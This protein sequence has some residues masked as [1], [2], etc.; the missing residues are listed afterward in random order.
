M[1]ELVV[2]LGD[3]VLEEPY[4][5]IAGQTYT[6]ELTGRGTTVTGHNEQTPRP[7]PPEAG[8]VMRASTDLTLR[9]NG[10]A[11]EP[12]EERELTPYVNEQVGEWV[13][14]NEVPVA[15]RLPI[16]NGEPRPGLAQ[17][18]HDII[19]SVRRTT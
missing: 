14:R 19:V 11:W 3:T 10:S 15:W 17:V 6:M 8:T 5:L 2:M 4:T 9:W 1:S 7:H 12:Y 16:V 13:V 18:G